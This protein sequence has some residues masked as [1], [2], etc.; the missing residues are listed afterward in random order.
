MLRVDEEARARRRE[1]DKKAREELADW[2]VWQLAVE[3]WPALADASRR[4]EL[5]ELK[6]VMVQL[7]RKCRDRMGPKK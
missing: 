2:Y 4:K 3:S 6:R 1:R 5:I 7:K